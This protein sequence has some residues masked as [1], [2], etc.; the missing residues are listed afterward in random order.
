MRKTI[1][2]HALSALL[3]ALVIRSSKAQSPATFLSSS[4]ESSS[5]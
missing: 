4:R 2:G 3:I 5:W 1:F